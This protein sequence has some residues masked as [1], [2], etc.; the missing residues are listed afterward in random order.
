MIVT[1]PA[2][3]VRYLVDA[4]ALGANGRMVRCARCSHTWHQAAPADARPIV[5][6]SDAAA[7]EA[8]RPGESPPAPSTERTPVPHAEE[9]I[10]LP[11]LARPAR[12]WGPAIGWA[13]AAVVIVGIAWLAITERT[14]VVGMV[15]QSAR[16]YRLLGLDVDAVGLG[17]E[18]RNVTTSRDMENGLPALVID[19]QVMNVSRVPRTV[20]KLVAVLRDR[21]EHELQDWSFTT[22]A[23][24]LQP[25]ESVP[26]HTS[27]IQP[28][29]EAAGVVVTFAGG[30]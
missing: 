15:P 13:S 22:A 21:S 10:R 27:I 1:C 7:P 28:A 20:P 5:A 25:G 26:F 8:P 14:A 12:P 30:G 4:G 3:S 29:D 24:K 2:C 16:A 11:A 23:D 18:F 9:R 19:G 17:L 6:A